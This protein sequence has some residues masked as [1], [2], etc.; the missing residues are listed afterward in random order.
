M[1]GLYEYINWRGDLDFKQARFNNLDALVLSMLSYINYD[2]ILAK[3]KRNIKTSLRDAAILYQIPNDAQMEIQMIRENINFFIAVS[4]TKR[5]GNLLIRQYKSEIHVEKTLQF[6]ALEFLLNDGTVFISF[7]GTD[8]TL[9]GWMENLSMG[10]LEIVPSQQRA[11]EYLENTQ[12]YRLKKIRLGGHSKGGNLAVYSSA[13]VSKQI[14]ARI[15]NIYNFDGP[16][17]HKSILESSGYKNIMPKIKTFVPETSIVGRLL[18]HQEDPLV[19][20]SVEIGIFQHDPFSWKIK[21]MDFLYS[22]KLDTSSRIVEEAVLNW[23]TKLELEKRKEF[24]RTIFSLFEVNQIYSIKQFKS[25]KLQMIK[26]LMTTYNALPKHDKKM[27]Q[28]TLNLLLNETKKS[29]TSNLRQ[30]KV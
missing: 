27:M 22:E 2:Y 17:F 28:E 23:L 19:I 6:A 14:Q 7:R 21:Y 10:Y 25:K 9:V 3:E 29:L 16:G 20:K 8:D 15:L 4:K 11:V 30:K 12:K 13:F 18:W 26:E 1:I 5:F 24:V